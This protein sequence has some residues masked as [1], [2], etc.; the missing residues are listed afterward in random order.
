MLWLALRFPHLP[1][2]ALG[3]Y[4]E[5]NQSIVVEDKHRVIDAS[6]GA[7]DAGVHQGMKAS[8]VHA[9]AETSVLER[10]PEYE[11]RALQRLAAWAY[12][13]TPY[14]Q[15]YEDNCL[16]LEVSRC[17]RLFGGIKTLCHKLQSSL[18]QRLHQY[19]MGLAHSRQGAWLLSHDSSNTSNTEQISDESS[20]QR[21]MAQIARMPLD[22]LS[23]FP[24][25]RDNLQQI[26][27]KTFGDLLQLPL[28]EL[29]QR[30]G[31]DFGDWL[32]GLSGHQPVTLPLHQLEEK[33]TASI[34]F[35]HPV[36]NIKLLE[37]PAEHLLQEFV[38]YLIEHQQEAQQ[39]DWYF[40]S[41]QGQVHTMSI[42]TERIHSQW[43]LL[44]DLTRIR[45]EQLQLYFEI[46]RLELRCDKTTAV[47]SKPKQL[48]DQMD[49]FSNQKIQ[50][51]AESMTARL[52]ARMG[53]N[54]VFLPSLRSEHL[55]EQQQAHVLP[56]SSDTSAQEQAKAADADPNHRNSN[57]RN[58][59]HRGPRPCWLFQKPH[60]IQCK[61]NHL[62]WKGA[63]QLV[64]GPERIEGKWWDHRSVR[65]YFIA[66]RDDHTRYWVYH[67][68]AN[69]SWH[70]Q[71]V[72]A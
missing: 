68:W 67:D 16:L 59:G 28:H 33:F 72:F 24:K 10:Q 51:E 54:A 41:P 19:Q 52:Q 20:Q 35:N 32:K 45:L 63:L 5:D 23:A 66:K 62:F 56:F 37:V 65:D 46:E 42:G 15:R 4:S 60:R 50:E 13:Y 58:S 1:L 30:F 64:Q 61:G 48:F 49:A 25:V 3:L 22:Y 8:A 39:I 40:Y 18:D 57:D 34:S 2:E 11:D 21:F 38:E 12:S 14:I 47:I 29:N 71:G 70:A 31:E 27:L 69:D 17:L 9:L 43:Q 36:N 6:T 53:S 26:G 7:L 44:L 55:P